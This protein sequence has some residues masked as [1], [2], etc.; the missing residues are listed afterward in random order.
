MSVKVTSKYEVE[1]RSIAYFLDC[2]ITDEY[3]DEL[4]SNSSSK[5]VG[6]RNRLSLQSKSIHEAWIGNSELIFLV[7]FIVVNWLRCNIL[8]GCL[9]NDGI[10]GIW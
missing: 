1:S 10:G 5:K 3:R 8:R 9:K 4:K 6:Y 2:T 7:F